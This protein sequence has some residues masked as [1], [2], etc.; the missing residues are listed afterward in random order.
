MLLKPMYEG[1]HGDNIS[2]CG[3]QVLEQPL[4]LW[5]GIEMA[6]D[7]VG[8]RNVEAERTSRRT[9]ILQ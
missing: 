9:N 1:V 2:S 3:L 6:G 7:A 5:M 8:A 4:A